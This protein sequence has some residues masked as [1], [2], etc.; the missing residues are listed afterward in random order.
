MRGD[1]TE[2]LYL[3][4]KGRTDPRAELEASVDALYD[5]AQDASGETAACRVP[6]RSAW[7]RE[8]LELGAGPLARASRIGGGF[9]TRGP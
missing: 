9:S 8:K 3:S 1:A 4:P 6:A 2:G 5:P 7:L